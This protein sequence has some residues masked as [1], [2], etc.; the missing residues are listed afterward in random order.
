MTDANI[1]TAI[2]EHAAILETAGGDGLLGLFDCDLYHYGEVTLESLKK[3]PVQRGGTDFRPFFAKVD[4]EA[5]KPAYAVL[6]TDLMGP[7][8]ERPPEYPVIFCVPKGYAESNPWPTA[9]I[10]EV[11]F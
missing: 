3:L 5:S 9:R 4:Q 11:E 1:R 7:F 2:S 6:F 10:I 8:P